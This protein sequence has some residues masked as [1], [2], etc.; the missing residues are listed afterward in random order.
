MTREVKRMLQDVTYES[1]WKFFNDLEFLKDD[2][3]KILNDDREEK[4][5]EDQDVME[6]VV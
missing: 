3:V 1:R 4:E 2:I 6:S 5:L